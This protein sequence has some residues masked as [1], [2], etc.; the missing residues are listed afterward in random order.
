MENNSKL[1]T[2]LSNY[3]KLKELPFG[4]RFAQAVN[5]VDYTVKNRKSD[6]YK[7]VDEASIYPKINQ[8]MVDWGICKKSVVFQPN[9]RHELID[10]S[11]LKDLNITIEDNNIAAMEK[12]L[13]EVVNKCTY[14]V[15]KDGNN[16][17][18]ITDGMVTVTLAD[19][20]NMDNELVFTYPYSG[21]QFFDPAKMHGTVM[22]YF[23]RYPYLKIFDVPTGED[24]P[25]LPMRLEEARTE[26]KSTYLTLKEA[27]KPTLEQKVMLQY[28][29]N[30]MFKSSSFEVISPIISKLPYDT[31]DKINEKLYAKAEEAKLKAKQTIKGGQS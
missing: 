25:D 24:D 4:Y 12:L 2:A 31:I 18:Y 3:E 28:L 15:N 7:Y 11:F 19:A 30:E 16:V 26:L 17:S 13:N 10:V 22:T 29:E 23:S 20:L 8:A 27:Q 1:E 14:S 5:D 21:Q 9:M 6:K